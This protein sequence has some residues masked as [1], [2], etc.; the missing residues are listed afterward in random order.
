MNDIDNGKYVHE[1]GAGVYEKSLCF[2]LN[3]VINLKIL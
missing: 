3:I 2:P 1:F